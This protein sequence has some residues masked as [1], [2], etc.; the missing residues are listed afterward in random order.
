MI[1]LILTT[2]YLAKDTVHRWFT[3]AS[4]PLARVLVVFFLSLCALCFL[5]SYVISA[6]AIRDKI[7]SRGGDLVAAFFMLPGESGGCLPSQKDTLEL[8][9]ADSIA[10]IP[11]GSVN[12]TERKL[13]PVITY[14]FRRAGQFMPLLPASGGPVVL[15]PENAPA[16]P[17]GPL[18]VTLQGDEFSITVPVRYL[19]ADHLLMRLQPGGLMLM[20][21]EMVPPE[22]QGR[23]MRYHRMML[24]VRELENAESLHRVCRY[25]NKLKQLEGWEGS[26]SS[27]AALLEEM[28]IILGNQNQCRAAFCLGIM[29]IVGILLTALAGME[30]RQNEFIYTLMKSFGINPLLLVGA[31]IVENLLL[32]AASFAGAVAVFMKAQKVIVAQFKLG[33]YSLSLEEIMPEIQLISVTLLICI[34]VSAIP[35]MVAANRQIGRVLK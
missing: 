14:D 1:S 9:G 34:L 18:D 8:L 24:Q 6:K 2:L 30:Y 19:P 5:G 7:R 10:I 21:P 17:R 26:V 20:P 23:A 3:R 22:S 31:F 4:S 15:C 12:V 13:L 33:Q 25:L 32:V 29:L 11:A 27:A 35:I 16:Y 28:D